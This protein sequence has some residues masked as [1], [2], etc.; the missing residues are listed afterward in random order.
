MKGKTD[1]MWRS[2]LSSAKLYKPQN[3]ASMHIIWLHC[4]VLTDGDTLSFL[5]TC[6]IPSVLMTLLYISRYSV[7]TWGGAQWTATCKSSTL[8]ETSC[9]Y[10]LRDSLIG[11]HLTVAAVHAGTVIAG[12]DYTVG[13]VV[14]IFMCSGVHSSCRHCLWFWKKE[15]EWKKFTFPTRHY[16]HWNRPGQ[17]NEAFFVETVNT[18]YV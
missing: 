5:K 8:R 12:S 17:F 16:F 7:P 6:N 13:V 1:R 10:V 4:G 18:K 14:T 3:L 11:T 2:P 15:V 9:R